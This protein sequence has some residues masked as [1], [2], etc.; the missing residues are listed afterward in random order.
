MLALV[1]V[2][3]LAL[4]LGLGVAWLLAGSLAR[5]LRALAG[6]A[7]GWPTGDLDARA[8]AEGSSEQRE[9]ATAFNDMT[10]RLGRTLRAQREFVANASHQL[11]T[12]LTGLRLRLEAADAEDRATPRCAREL[13]AAERETVR[14]AALLDP[15]AH[16]RARV[17]APERGR[18]SP[19]RRRREA[20]HRALGGTGAA[21]R[22]TSCGSSAAR[23]CSPVASPART[24]RRCST[25]WSRTRSTTRPPA[26]TVTIES[27]GDATWARLARERRGA[28]RRPRRARAR[29]R[30]LLPRER[31][32]ADRRAPAS[33][34]PWW[35]RSPSAGVARPRWPTASPAARVPRCACPPRPCR[36]LTLQLDKA[37]PGAG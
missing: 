20:A 34:W 5:P 37:L 18:L 17:R 36:P 15:A 10:D 4:L 12:P 19:R 2:G 33:G 7:R 22:A 31:E 6:T 3:A 25:T 28:R 23:A 13:A 21:A 8:A 26:P 32:H 1:G 27:G 11:R 16:A 35:R 24:W 14:L 29:L 30:A 9:V